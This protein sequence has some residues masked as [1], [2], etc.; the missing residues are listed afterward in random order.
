MVLQALA[1]YARHAEMGWAAIAAAVITAAVD[2]LYLGIVSSQG[3]GNPEFIRIPFVATFIAL[4]AI[5]CALS[6]RAS[7]ARWRPLLLGVAAAGLL[8]LGFFA[9][10][11]IGAPLAL[12]GALALLALIHTLTS[13]SVRGTSAR[14]A[15]AKA[16]G[17]AI[18]AVVVLL[19]GFLVADYA[20][21][22]PS[23]G[24]EGGSGTTLLGA[25]YSY[26]CD[27]GRLTISRQ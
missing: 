9:L 18:A 19:A 11:S 7:A 3:G 12:A 15:A 27:N 2:V 22:C 25:S 20:I 23:S 17:G 26:S 21:R 14:A 5:C 16:V 10:F 8:L 1:I 6:V 4:M 13:A 24:Q